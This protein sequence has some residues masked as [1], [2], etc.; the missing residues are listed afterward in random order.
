MFFRAKYIATETKNSQRKIEESWMDDQDEIQ[1][2]DQQITEMDKLLQEAKKA[3]DMQAWARE[4]GIDLD[5]IMASV[6]RR[7]SPAEFEQAQRQAEEEFNQL[8]RELGQSTR[9]ASLGQPGPAAR[10]G[11]RSMV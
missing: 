4:N 6:R 1:K 11:P 3:L 10:R 9:S 7:C 2:R 5:K 8:A